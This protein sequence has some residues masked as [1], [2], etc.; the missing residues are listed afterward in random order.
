LG[1][2]VLGA[3][4]TGA[5]DGVYGSRYYAALPDH[6]QAESSGV[7]KKSEPTT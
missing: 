3:V 6:V 1:A 4:V 7:M 2:N 5:H